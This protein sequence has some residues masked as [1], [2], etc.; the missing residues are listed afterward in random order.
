MVNMM[1]MMMDSD[2]DVDISDD[3]KLKYT[4]PGVK[5]CNSTS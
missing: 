4:I 1:E 3:D 5:I 2:C